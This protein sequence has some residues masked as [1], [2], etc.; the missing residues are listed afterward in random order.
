M[1]KNLAIIV[2]LSFILLVN[3]NADWAEYGVA[4]NCDKDSST[5]EILPTVESSYP[6]ADVKAP[7]GFIKLKNATEQHHTCLL[8]A[9]KIELDIDVYGPQARGMG[10]GSGVI[11][12]NNLKAN[13]NDLIS[14]RTNFNWVVMGEQVLTEVHIKKINGILTLTKCTTDEWDWSPSYGNK[15]CKTTTLKLESQKK[16]EADSIVYKIWVW[17]T[18]LF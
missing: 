12:I 5:F 11:V 4:I 9:T 18:N 3:V 7:N 16:K 10:Q 14:T 8:G 6:T 13:S 15:K 1:K 17:F 2:F